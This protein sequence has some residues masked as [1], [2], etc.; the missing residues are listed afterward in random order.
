SDPVYRV[1]STTGRG[2]L[3]YTQTIQL[4]GPTREAVQWTKLTA[5]GG[6]TN[7][8]FADGGR[9]DDAAAASWYAFPHIAVNSQGDFLLGYSRFGAALHP[10]TGYSWHDHADA[11]GTL[12]DPQIYKAGEDYYH[13]TFSTTTGRNR[14]GDFSTAQ[15]DPSDDRTLWVLQEY[16]QART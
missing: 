3:Y 2:Y 13:K 14:W 6:G 8:G 7:P 9:L 4:S 12:R 11:A 1:D 10:A 5:A 15:V 16:G